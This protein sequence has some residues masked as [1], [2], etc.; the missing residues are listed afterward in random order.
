MENIF[1]SDCLFLGKISSEYL[2][3]YRCVV[4]D[5]GF[6]MLF[7]FIWFKLLL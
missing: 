3:V 7:S 5:E 1:F 4:N 6:Y 2:V